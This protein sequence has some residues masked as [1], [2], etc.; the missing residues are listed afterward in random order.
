MT[1]GNILRFQL[2]VGSR[3]VLRFQCP[4]HL[5]WPINT[6]IVLVKIKT[7]EYLSIL[8]VLDF[9]YLFNNCLIAVRLHPEDARWRVTGS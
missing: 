4:V 2:L 1:V 3:Q 6:L 9:K 8:H 7:S 5:I